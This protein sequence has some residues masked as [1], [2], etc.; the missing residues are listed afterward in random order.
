MV[1]SFLIFFPSS[2]QKDRNKS[3]IILS[4]ICLFLLLVDLLGSLGLL[5]VLGL[6]LDFLDDTDGNGLS[7][8][9][10]G[11]ATQRRVLGELLDAHWLG[12]HQLDDGSLL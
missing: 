11:E 6:D 2:L 8:V 1:L 9:S 10:D 12:G 5:G 4:N 7:H 3:Q